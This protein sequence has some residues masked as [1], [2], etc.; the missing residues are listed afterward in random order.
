[1]DRFL[2]L[3][4]LPRLNQEEIEIMNNPITSSDQKSPKKHFQSHL[5]WLLTQSAW[6]FLQKVR[7]PSQTREM[8]LKM[9]FGPP[10]PWCRLSKYFLVATGLKKLCCKLFDS[11]D[12]VL[13]IFP[14]CFLINSFEKYEKKNLKKTKAQDQKSSQMNSIKHLE[15][16]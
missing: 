15:T 11:F 12:C 2:E 5:S 3:F 7:L 8:G 13:Y 1:M 14:P 9:E 4:N 6:N 10:Y 16:G